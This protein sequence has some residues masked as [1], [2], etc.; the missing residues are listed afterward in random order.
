[1]ADACIQEELGYPVY[2]KPVDSSKGGDIYKVPSAN[3]LGEIMDSESPHS[4]IKVN[5]KINI[6][7]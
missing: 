1:M 3:E 4:V 5:A 2:T 7:L 6:V